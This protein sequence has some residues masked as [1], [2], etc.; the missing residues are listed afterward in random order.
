MPKRTRPRR[1]PTDDYQQ[2]ALWA[3][4]PEHRTFELIRPVV[5][6][7]QSP[8]ERARETGAAERTI[9]RKADRFDAYGMASLFAADEPL[10]RPEADRIDRRALPPDVRQLIVDLK[11][12]YPPLHPKELATIL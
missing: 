9:R 7:G 2:L 12:E 1:T 4:G 10:R 8:A 11:R 6:F 3:N 5:L